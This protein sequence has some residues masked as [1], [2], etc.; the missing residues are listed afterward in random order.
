MATINGNYR[1]FRLD[2]GLFVALQETPTQ[3]VAGRLRVW[4]GAL[5]EK[6]GEDGLAHFLEHCLMTGGSE[7]YS[8]LMAKEIGNTLGTFNAFTG[9]ERTFFPVEMLTEH[10]PLFLDYISDAVFNPKFD[11][12]CVERE[13]QRVLR[14]TADEKSNPTF[15][16][17]KA[18]GIAFFGEDSPHIYPILG[19]ES[20]VGSMSVCSLR[21]FHERGYSP[22]NMDLIMV[23]ALP[24]DIEGLIRQNFA[25]FKSGC[26]KRAE[27]PRNPPL[28]GAK[29]LH[30]SASDLLNHEH[31][32]QSSAQLSI[33]MFAPVETDSD[34][35]AVAM[36]V[37]ILG[38][39]S[40]S[41][42][43][44]NISQTKGLAYGI[45]ALYDRAYNKGGI[46]I[47]GDVHAER[48]EE[49]IDAAFEEMAKMRTT[50]VSQAR[51]EMIKKRSIYIIAKTFETNSGHVNAI[52]TKIDEGMTPEDMLKKLDAVTPQDIM[53]AAIK[54]LP[55]NRA[56]GKYVLFLRDP[57]KR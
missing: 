13:K 36:M 44:S 52:E 57:L 16:D 17:R 2:N 23:G 3:T 1:E 45:S 31:P 42:L 35:Y 27:F 18:Y 11:P 6:P 50:L 33:S 26:G 40:N 54:Y 19:N 20:V 7:K 28:Y 46:Y 15:L 29:I 30:M 25:H 5:N 14:E 49:A 32:E 56:D 34:A 41:E 47:Y 43:F 22:N 12:V 8:P 48:A 51:L 53:D 38:G 21:N 39:D 4:H 37:R 24:K 10:T 9:L 55:Q